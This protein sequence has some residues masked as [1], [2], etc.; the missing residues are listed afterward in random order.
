MTLRAHVEMLLRR[1]NATLRVARGQKAHVASRTIHMPLREELGDDEWY[2]VVLHE[3]GHL[4]TIHSLEERIPPLRSTL[5]A[6]CRDFD[7]E[8]LR[9]EEAA[10]RF[11]RCAALHWTE[12]MERVAQRGLQSYRVAMKAS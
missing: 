6:W 7:N 8:T 9:E 4:A 2:A 1:H 5:N 11:A 12:D 10:W 3:I